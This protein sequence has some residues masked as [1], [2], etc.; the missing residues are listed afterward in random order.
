MHHLAQLQARPVQDRAQPRVGLVRALL[1]GAHVRR[2]R[3]VQRVLDALQLPQV[4]KQRLVLAHGF[5]RD[6]RVER[7]PEKMKK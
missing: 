3:A 2:P 5:G 7:R 4:R 6:D 1:G